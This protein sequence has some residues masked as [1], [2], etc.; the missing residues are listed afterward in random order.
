[1]T[2]TPKGSKCFDVTNG[3][4][5]SNGLGESCVPSRTSITLEI[6]IGVSSIVVI[7]FS[8]SNCTCCC[9]L[10]FSLLFRAILSSQTFKIPAIFC[11]SSKTG[12]LTTKFCTT[13]ICTL[14][15]PD[16]PTIDLIA[17]SLTMGLQTK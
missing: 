10:S 16:E 9:K 5:A 14:W 2:S 8:Y 7:K 12:T 1:M 13:S 11:C 4:P 17:A 3:Y 6:A 15:R